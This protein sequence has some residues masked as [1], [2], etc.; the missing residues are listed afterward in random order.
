MAKKKRVRLTSPVGIAKYP[1]LNK[2][3]TKF[4]PQ[5]VFRVSLLLDPKEHKEFLERLDA[6]VDQSV[7]EA[8]KELQK[9]RPQDVAKLI[10]KPAYEKEYDSEGVETGMVEVKFKMKHIINTKN[11]DMVLTPDI[12][13][14]KGKVID[15]SE[16]KIFGG[17]KLRINFTP[18][19]YYMASTK[20]AGVSMQLNAVQVIELA[21]RGADSSFYGF[22]EVEDGFDADVYTTDSEKDSSS[23]DYETPDFDEEDF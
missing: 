6:M 23:E 21:E 20:M 2:P 22:G 12:F 3:D 5:G 14:A 10:E 18:N 11:G 7:A 1:W 8:K 9:K 16:V 15:R 17:S 19:P 4:D 13:D